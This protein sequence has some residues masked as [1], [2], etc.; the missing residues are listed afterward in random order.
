MSHDRL[1]GSLFENLVLFELIKAYANAGKEPHLYYYRDNH[2][3]E[4]DIIVKVRN[5]LIPIEVKSTSTFNVSLIKNLKFYQS[6]VGDRMP[7]G[8]LV[9]AGQ[10]ENQVGNFHVVNYKSLDK[11][12][13][14]CEGF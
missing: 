11:V 10:Q 3:N 6:L 13:Q 4:I 14:L 9:Y 2:H 5:A 7:I 8:F 12:F 1:R